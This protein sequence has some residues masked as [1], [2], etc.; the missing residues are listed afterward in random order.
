MNYIITESH[1]KLITEALGVPDFILDAAEVFYE[2][3][4]KD[5]STINEINDVYDF[6][7]NVN[8]LL[9]DKKKIPITEYEL[10][11]QVEEIDG[12]D[13]KPTIYSMGMAQSFLFDRDIMMKRTPESTTAKFSM[14]FAVG[15]EWE[16]H[17]LY[18]EFAKNEVQY[19]SSI[20]H[21][22]KHK[23]DKQAKRVG[24]LGLEAEYAGI[25]ESPRFGIPVIDKEFLHYIY[26]TDVAE[27]LVRP[28]E[29]A[30]RIRTQNISKEQFREFLR[31][32][33]TFQKLIK[34]KNFTFEDLINGIKEHMDRVDEILVK[35]RVNDD[36]M[37]DEDK[38]NKILELVYINLSNSKTNQFNNMIG[39]PISD[40]FSLFS[41]FG[42]GMSPD[43]IKIDKLKEKFYNYAT[44]Y[45]S[46]PI[47]YFKDEIKNFH[48]VADQMIKKLSK[49]YAMSSQTTTESIIDWELRN[50]VL[51][52]K[53]VSNTI[54][55]DYKFRK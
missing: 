4:K 49:L 40:L 29:V 14:T 51:D 16:P 36:Q 50:R 35:L 13:K 33:E 54:D 12:Y 7:G 18:E 28:S 26:Y 21:E 45:R 1:L 6:K 55:V 19:V 9:G 3:F 20:A 8:I 24:L 23:Y 17:E 25:Q 15:S 10:N 41:M 48:K 11:I 27:S 38:I 34:I 53:Q 46:N 2:I 32:D 39:S 37:S 44:K 31:N 30:S 47:Q 42:S 22:L 5:L 52:Q 43:S